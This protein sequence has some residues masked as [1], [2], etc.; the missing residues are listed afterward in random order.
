MIFKPA[1]VSEP[2]WTTRSRKTENDGF[3]TC[4]WFSHFTDK[5]LYDWEIGVI[6]TREAY[7]DWTVESWS[8]P[9]PC[10]YAS[11]PIHI[12]SNGN[13]YLG[14][15]TPHMLFLFND[16]SVATMFKLTWQ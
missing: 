4:K 13:I 7:E 2:I 6:I 16:L 3:S 11:V 1:G 14:D 8:D 15:Y 12:I 5:T 10:P 9:M